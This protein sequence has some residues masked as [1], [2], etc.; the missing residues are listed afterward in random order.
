MRDIQLPLEHLLTSSQPSLE[1]FELSR[2]ACSSNLRKEI[3]QVLDEWVE[4]EVGARL[5]R[6]ILQHRRTQGAE[7]RT[8]SPKPNDHVC[9]EQPSVHFLLTRDELPLPAV[10][11]HDSIIPAPQLSCATISRS[12]G[13]QSSLCERDSLMPHLHAHRCMN[14]AVAL[15]I[16]SLN[17]QRF[18]FHST[19]GLKRADAALRLLQHL[20]GSHAR[21]LTTFSGSAPALSDNGSSWKHPISPPLSPQSIY[22][23]PSVETSVCRVHGRLHSEPLHGLAPAQNAR[24]PSR[25]FA[26]YPRRLARAS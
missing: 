6:W 9:P 8:L 1:E 14:S 26:L 20:G 11:C 4:A 10:L 24:V 18:S 3:C 19:T 15:D 23:N 25:H 16:P 12:S 7:S 13:A 22:C 5:T 2:L 21:T 17:A